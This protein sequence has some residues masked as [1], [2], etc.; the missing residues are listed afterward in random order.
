VLATFTPSE[1]ARQKYTQTGAEETELKGYTISGTPE[2][3][4]GL[5]FTNGGTEHFE[6]T[7]PKGAG[8]VLR[9]RFLLDDKGQTADVIVNGK[10]AGKWDLRRATDQQLAGGFREACFLVRR[11]SIGESSTCAVDLRYTNLA[12]TAAWTLLAYTG[13]DFPLSALGALHGDSGVIQPRVARNVVGLPLQIG[14]KV[15]TNGMGVFAPALLEYPLNGQFSRFTAEAGVASA[16]EGKGSVVFEVYGDGKKL[17]ASP[18]MS[19]L[20]APKAVDVS[21][22]GVNRLRLVVSDGGDGNRFDAANWCDASLF[23]K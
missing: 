17:W 9:K 1:G 18:V 20:D 11:E 14:K 13:G 12:T 8:L 5:V 3:L 15:Y 6:V 10:S 4:R 2:A 16:T 21:V 22:E 7:L 23:V 19:G